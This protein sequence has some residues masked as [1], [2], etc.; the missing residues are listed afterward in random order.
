MHPLGALAN[1]IAQRTP[2]RVVDQPVQRHS[3]GTVPPRE[4]LRYVR[5]KPARRSIPHT[6][7]VI[8]R[9]QRL[10]A[11]AH[12]VERFERID[13]LLAG[14]L[15]EVEMLAPQSQAEFAGEDS[16]LIAHPRGIPRLTIVDVPI[17]HGTGHFAVMCPRAPVEVVRTDHR[18]YVVYD[19]YLGVHIDRCA[20]VVLDVVDGEAVPSGGPTYLDRLLS[21][22]QARPPRRPVFVR[23]S[24]HYGYHVQIRLGAQGIGNEISDERCPQI[25]ILDVDQTARA[26]EN[27]P[28]GIPDASLTE[29]RE[30]VATQS[31]G[32]SAKYLNGVR[33]DSGWLWEWSR[34]LTTNQLAGVVGAVDRHPHRTRQ[35]EHAAPSPSLPEGVLDISNTRA[36]DRGLH[37]MPR[38]AFTIPGRKVHRLRISFVLAAIVPAQSQIDASDERH[39]MLRTS[40]VSDDDE[41]LMVR[42]AAAG[43]RIQQ[44]LAAGVR[45]LSNQLGILTFALVQPARLRSPDQSEDQDTPFGQLR[46]DMSDG[47]AWAAEE[48]FGVS[49]KIGKI[50][51]VSGPRR[52][53]GVIQRREVAGAVDERFDRIARRPV[54][55]VG[56]TVAPLRIDKEPILNYRPRGTRHERQSV[57]DERRRLPQRASRIRHV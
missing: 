8:P 28:V 36:P 3:P 14:V 10:G 19:D 11:S 32:I 20:G 38:R 15:V 37:V 24:R 31:R 21:S 5:S 22:D 54:P 26:D 49:A 53:E 25:L 12:Q 48:F 30:W 57:E 1:A 44:D 18:P 40:R 35:I 45:H 52:T 13:H 46:E 9:L 34:Q 43:T 55:N 7:A 51:L 27:F 29:R 16:C 56:R 2:V 41:L 17:K 33:T 6:T 47:G 39:I 4:A 42:S 50:D 23:E